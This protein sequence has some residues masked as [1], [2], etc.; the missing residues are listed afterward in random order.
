MFEQAIGAMASVIVD[1]HL[2]GLIF[3]TTILGV[4]IGVLPGLGA[5][6]GATEA[7]VAQPR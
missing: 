7:P 3:V 5:T 2:L 4:I 6:T 1:P